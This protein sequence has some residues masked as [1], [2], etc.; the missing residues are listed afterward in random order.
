[1]QFSHSYYE[2]E[3]REGFYI[4]SMMKCAWAAQMELLED[5]GEV[6]KK[7]NIAYFVTYGTLL[8]A[9]RHRG[10]IPWDDDMD[11]CM[12]RPDYNRFMTIA[13]K[14]LPQGYRLLNVYQEAA[15]DEVFS[16][17]V[18]SKSIRFDSAFLEKFHGFPYVAGVDIFPLDYLASD[19]EEVQLLSNLIKPIWSYADIADKD[20][21]NKD[22]LEEQVRNIEELCNV[23]IDRNKPIKNELFCLTD[24]LFSIYT[25]EESDKIALT[26]NWVKKPKIIWK[27]DYYK[28]TVLL[29]FEGME[30]PAPI[31]YDRILKSMYG[32]YMKAV[33]S[34][35]DEHEYPFYEKQE[36]VFYEHGNSFPSK[37][38]FHLNDFCA[39]SSGVAETLLQMKDRGITDGD[40][41]NTGHREVLFLPY[42]ASAWETLEN[43]WKSVIDDPLCDVYV[44]PIPYFDKKWGGS[45]GEMH[46]DTESYPDY[47]PIT[48]YDAFDLEKH[49]P[50]IV[51]VQFPYDEH[52]Y[53]IDIEPCF[54]VRNLVRHT[55]RLIYIPCIAADETVLKNKKA[56]ETA[57]AFINV[58][59]VFYADRVIVQSVNMRQ[60][61]IDIL[62][63]F[64]G[65]DTREIWEDKIEGVTS[66]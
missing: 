28:K 9:V 50:D 55:N 13:Q 49:H 63:E 15:W 14:E 26:P 44:V 8:G 6:C 59:G 18:N 32:E 4:P 16:R 60:I 10:F 37:Y 54:Y 25:E 29:P 36:S 66:Q 19:D 39:N 57:K 51:Y 53:T 23:K 52:H 24:R 33:Y 17:V 21:V 34:D 48:R 30:V 5:I 1:M 31:E 42:K 38:K 47:V 2:D 35:D 43:T 41:E 61:Y 20:F 62:T 58:P 3:V 12:P 27:K 7:H 64:A 65:E 45:H 40:G 46:Y 22:E 56:L 11:I